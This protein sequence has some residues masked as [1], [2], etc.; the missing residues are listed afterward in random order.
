LLADALAQLA[1]SPRERCLAV[2][3]EEAVLLG[4]DFDSRLI[5]V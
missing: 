5:I 4:H 1:C 2:K 3:L